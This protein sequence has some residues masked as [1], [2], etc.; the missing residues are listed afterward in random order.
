MA[1]TGGS[2]WITNATFVANQAPAGADIAN[3][4]GMVTMRN[5]T[6]WQAT[7][8]SIFND[9]VT[10]SGTWM[11]NSAVDSLTGP[12]CVGM[13]N[14]QGNVASDDTCSGL[15]D[16][17]PGFGTLD[18]HGG[19]VRTVNLIAGSAAVDAGNF[20]TCQAVDARGISRPQ[21][22]QCDAGAFEVETVYVPV[23][24][25]VNDLGDDADATPGDTLCATATSVCTLRAAIDEANAMTAA[26]SS[27]VPDVTVDFATDGTITVASTLDVAAR[28]AIDGGSHRVTV[29][30]ANAVRVFRF[31]DYQ[32]PY[33]LRHLTI[34][35]GSTAALEGGAGVESISE[36]GTIDR[37][38]FVDNAVT[39]PSSPGQAGGAAVAVTAGHITVSNSTFSGNSVNAT[40]GGA[41]L[42]IRGTASVIH[43]TFGG[44]SGGS[45]FA[46]STYSASI[47][48]DNS[49]VSTTGGFGCTGTITGSAN[50]SADSAPCGGGMTSTDPQFVDFGDHGGVVDTWAIART[51]PAVDAADSASCTPTDARD[52]S[53]PKGAQCDI[54]ALEWVGRT[55]VT[56]ASTA[57]PSVLTQP[58][59]ITANVTSDD[60]TI[61]T[62]TLTFLEGA[63]VLGTAVL[64]VAGVA[65][66]ELPSLSLGSHEITVD[67]PGDGALDPSSA[68]IT[69]QVD[70]PA[71]QVTVT[72]P[73]ST[74]AGSDVSLSVLVDAPGATAAPTGTLTLREGAT[75]I[76]TKAASA[77]LVWFTVS[78]PSTG[79]HN[80]TV[81]YDGDGVYP[82]ASGT[83]DVVVGAAASSVALT[84]AG[85]TVHGQGATFTATVT[86]PAPWLIPTGTVTFTEGAT[87]LGTATLD[88][89]GTAVFV[90]ASLDVGTHGIT[91]TYEGDVNHLGSSASTSHQVDP[92]STSIVVGASD[93]PTVH[94]E[95]VTL[96]A[97][98][99]VDAPG[100]GT[101][102]GT[103]R[104]F[105]GVT[106]LGTATLAAD[107]TT[108][109]ALG[110][111]ST[112][113]H[114]I[115]AT[116]DG[117]SRRNSS[118]GTYDHVVNPAGTSLGLDVT[119]G[120]I[121]AGQAVTLTATV[122]VV[123][124]GAGSP[125]GTVTFTDGVTV[126]GVAAVDGTGVATLSGISFEPGDHE[127]GA[128]YGGDSDF[129]T[130]T[131]SL[132]LTVTKA[133]TSTVVAD[134]VDTTV[135][136]EGVELT[137]TVAVEAPGTGIPTGTVTFTDGATVLGSASLDGTGVATLVVT[138]LEPGSRTVTAT[139]EGDARS[140]VSNGSVEHVVNQAATQVSLVPS[141]ASSVV[142]A[143]VTFTATVTAV[144]PGAGV[145]T[146]SIVFTDGATTLGTVA[147]D[148][149]GTAELTTWSLGVGAHSIGAVF[150]GDAAYLGSSELLAY[151]VDPAGAD[152]V[153]IADAPST[154]SG[155]AVTFTATVT[156]VPVGAIPT[157]VVTFLDGM[158]V[159]GTAGL[160]ATGTAT[161]TTSALSVGMHSVS[162]TYDGD[163]TVGAGSSL[164]L[165]HEVQPASS[166]LVVTSSGSPTVWGESVAITASVS[167]VA[168]G[169]GLP[170]G[171]VVFRE[172]AT[173]LGTVPVDGFGFATLSIPTLS[174]GDHTITADYS[175]DSSFLASSGA[176]LQT[177]E[178]ATATV[179]VT[180]SGSSTVWGE[181]LTI[182]AAVS[183]DAPGSGIA[184]GTVS[185]R[186]GAT[187]LGSATLDAS[188]VAS[189]TIDSLP[190]GSHVLVA[191]YSGDASVD[192]QTASIAHSVDQ[193]T[194]NV[195][196]T[197][198]P[199]P[200]V[201]GQPVTLMA[202]VSV[203]SPGSG[204]ATGTVTFNDG[205]AILGTAT[206]DSSGQAVLA[207][208][209]L[210][211]GT[212]SISA[213]YGG[214]AS[215]LSGSSLDVSHVVDRA[216]SAVAVTTSLPASVWGQPVAVTASVTVVAPGSA[217]PTGTVTFTDGATELGAVAL[218]ATG[219]ATLSTADLDLGART[220]TATYAGDANVM[221]G[222]GTVSHSVTPAGA[223]VGLVSSDPST[224]VGQPV[225]FT[226]TVSVSAPGS[227]T[228]T[229]SVT[230]ES[231]GSPLGSAVV[232]GLGVASLT[233][234][235]LGVGT[236]TVTATYTGDVNVTGASASVAQS[237]AAASTTTVITS[238]SNP[239]VVGQPVTFDVSVTPSG[240][241]VAATGTVEVFDGA[242]LVASAAL[243]ATGS[244][245]VVVADLTV[246]SHS[247]TAHYLGTS[248][249]DASVSSAITQSVD[250]AGSTVSLT[251]DTNP[252]VAGQQVELTAL[253]TSIPAGTLPTGTVTFTDG[254]LT[255]ATAVLDAT[256][257]ATLNT[258]FTAGDHQLI[259]SYS[260]DGTVGP[261][262]STAVVQQVSQ[263]TTSA[264]IVA[265]ASAPVTG[266][267]IELT[268]TI[269]TDAPSVGMPTGTVTFR[270]NATVIGTASLDADGQAILSVDG[271]SA[272]LHTL[273]AD[274]SGDLNRQAS[275]G[276]L[277]LTVAP[278]ATNLA[279]TASSDPSSYGE[280]VTL[281]A[282]V[283]VVAPGTDAVTG[284][285]TGTVT[286]R[287]GANVLA[288]TTL[289]GLGQASHAVAL[290]A[291]VHTIA[292]DYEGDTNF[293]ASTTTRDITVTA[294]ATTLDLAVT[295]P[296]VYGS[297][298]TVTVT[299]STATGVPVTGCVTV[300]FDGKT[301]ICISLNASGVG[302]FGFSGVTPG[303]YAVNASYAGTAD[304][305]PA[306]ATPASATVVAAPTTVAL[307]ASPAAVSAYGQ[308]VS[309]TAT[310]A[311]SPNLSMPTGT[312]AFSSNGVS[313][314]SASVD[315]A[316]KATLP[317]TSLVVG[318]NS[319]V[320]TFTSTNGY[321]TTT[322]PTLS[323]TVTPASTT[324]A[325]SS[326]AN[327]AVRGQVLTLT[328]TVAA[329]SPGGGIPAGTVTFFDG[330]D[331]IGT[332][333]TDAL[334]VAE[335]VT[336]TLAVGAHSLTASFASSTSYSP[337]TS[338]PLAIQ[339]DRSP[340]AVSVTSATTPSVYGQPV[341][342]TALVTATSSGLGVPTGTVTFTDT[343]NGASYGPV[344]LD[345]GGRASAAIAPAVSGTVLVVASYSGDADVA[346]SSGQVNQQVN[347]A[348]TTLTL[349]NSPV[350]PVAG[351]PVSVT[352]TLAAVS[353]GAGTPT[354]NVH[355]SV[356]G[357]SPVSIALDAGGRA[358]INLTGPL[359]EPVAG[360][361]RVTATYDGDP[362]RF[363]P[364]N[365]ETMVRVNRA[366]PT[367]SVV[368]DKAVSPLGSPVTFTASFARPDAVPI[369]AEVIT[370]SNGSTVL[371]S[372]PLTWNGQSL[373]ASL[374]TSALAIGAQTVTASFP[375]NDN[376]VP[377][378]ASTTV[379]VGVVP[380]TLNLVE[381]NGGT[382]GKVTHYIAYVATDGTALPAGQV[383]FSIDGAFVTSSAVVADV[384]PGWGSAAFDYTY[385]AAG[386]HTVTATYVPSGMFSSSTA[387]VTSTVYPQQ[388]TLRISAP[389][390]VQWGEHVPVTVTV[391]SADTPGVGRTGMI[392]IDDGEGQNCSVPAD[393]GGRCSLWYESPGTRTLRATYAGDAVWAPATA[394]TSVDVNYRTPTL[395]G[396]VVTKQVVTGAPT[397]V[398]WSLS[399][400]PD[401]PPVTVE[402]PGGPSCSSQLKTGW[403]DLVLPAETADR[404]VTFTISYP[405]DG[406]YLPARWTSAPIAPLGCYPLDVSVNPAGTAT[407]QVG[408][409]ASC[410]GGR[411]YPDGTLVPVVVTPV[412]GFR[413]PPIDPPGP[414]TRW[415][416]VGNPSKGR[417]TQLSV[418]TE[419][420][421]R[422]V[423]LTLAKEEI[424]GVGGS[425][426]AASFSDK[427]G[428]SGAPN[429]VIGPNGYPVPGTGRWSP[430]PYQPGA[431]EGLFL[432]GT[433][434][435]LDASLDRLGFDGHWFY[436]FR[437][438]GPRSPWS[439]AGAQPGEDWTESVK[440]TSDTSLVAVF[441]PTCQDVTAGVQGPGEVK[442]ATPQNCRDPRRSGWRLGT[443]VTF[444][445]RTQA[446]AYVE[447][448]RVPRDEKNLGLKWLPEVSM[449]EITA[450][451]SVTTSSSGTGTG[452]AISTDTQKLTVE[453]A[454]NHVVA[455]FNTCTELTMSIHGMGSVEASPD[456]NCPTMSGWHF[457][458]GTK[459]DLTAVGKP[460]VDP[461]LPEGFRGTSLDDWGPGIPFELKWGLGAPGISLVMDSDRHI[462][463]TFTTI[464]ACSYLVIDIAPAG[465]GSVST[466]GIGSHDCPN[467]APSGP[468]TEKTA[469]RVDKQSR[470]V[471]LSA[472]P[473]R[474]APMVGWDLPSYS[475]S[476]Y[477][478]TY[479]SE[480][481]RYEQRFVSYEETSRVGIRGTDAVTDVYN[482]GRVTAAFCQRIDMR[483]ALVGVDGK[484]KI[485]DFPGGADSIADDDAIRVYP[486]PNCPYADDAWI[487]G[488]DVEVAALADPAGF[489]FKAWSGASVA[490]TVVTTVHLDGA[491][492]S[493]RLTATYDLRCVTL[494]TNP[495]SEIRRFPEPNCLG[496][497]ASKNRYVGGT[498][499]VLFGRL[500]SDTVFQGWSGDV[501]SKDDKRSNW[502][503]MDRD[504]T[505]NFNYRDKDVWET[506]KS[507]FEWLGD[508]AAI[509]A[510]KAVGVLA[511]GIGS[512]LASA[513]PL[514]FATLIA[515]ISGVIGS[516]LGIF[517]VD[518]DITTYLKYIQETVAF[519]TAGFTCA[520][521]WGMSSSDTSSRDGNLGGQ[522]GEIGADFTV[523]SRLNASQIRDLERDIAQL[524]GKRTYGVNLTD[525]SI[526]ETTGL[527]TKAKLK[528]K[529]AQLTRNATIEPFT[530]KLGAAVDLGTEIYSIS[531]SGSGIG[532]DSSAKSAWTN[533][534]VFKNCALEAVPSMIDI[535]RPQS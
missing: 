428:W 203:A 251:S 234:D 132:D 488:T 464:G 444:E 517:G 257:T 144:A 156:A 175:G 255:I 277:D 58:V 86:G 61:P 448:W 153:V 72:G 238:S 158:T 252:S 94:G 25:T 215:V 39:A 109:L 473:S 313:L 147:L 70:S 495:A 399:G 78:R 289:D 477:T 298:V 84:T 508:Q 209:D 235:L 362:G 352:A 90:D 66:L 221:S 274:Y 345:A 452:G 363:G 36:S 465:A 242:T 146:G 382:P 104:F 262:V 2:L 487:V 248:S 281:A 417:V 197:S 85:S 95:A 62:G 294:V 102:T 523:T 511:A 341:V 441:G 492:R 108:S 231:D 489:T 447:T 3:S 164:P 89:T 498:I 119:T 83:V 224:T 178:P 425:L 14:G 454:Q 485:E 201:V 110:A 377:V 467:T 237:V 354:G 98:V 35:D 344:T 453:R 338:T 470:N 378:A 361:Y 322:S 369:P 402:V 311:R 457:K 490:D 230:F 97:A 451:N 282:Q 332:A 154:V 292:I 415:V 355:F 449:Y 8:G 220:I 52:V 481:N 17:S 232:D 63:T 118:A 34:R 246:G 333:S 303:T 288:T 364:S 75:V 335:L 138:T 468:I 290:P 429:C 29:S 53:R 159:V 534:D 31:S 48:L 194:S 42:F 149:S 327:P 416:T 315:S 44:S 133:S 263:A 11:D 273:Y 325:L 500:P 140:L 494:T 67:Y 316:G 395:I 210:A 486:E 423:T 32:S 6:L 198:S 319:V 4:A 268:A 528:Y 368:A 187:V 459:V 445:A 525:N 359:G 380:T 529:Q 115:T 304:I 504:K 170:T 418:A 405:G 190:V 23:N 64:D 501:G 279:V 65:S 184:T 324:T 533:G 387:T 81:E 397:R 127:L 267:P 105:E 191:D 186:S 93:G 145:P 391:S 167:V 229:G 50:I 286:F 96:T 18:D 218:D 394:A 124:P 57:N 181:S 469:L 433:T 389:Q 334:G 22:A 150:G 103:V 216:A 400:G 60:G 206:L 148:S 265:D 424:A 245:S 446:P 353:P 121:V 137:A 442:I 142:G 185:F 381:F 419:P 46:D 71:T 122:G 432:V 174:V 228:P 207:V 407:V 79:S 343:A 59:T 196:V 476:E 323:H 179:V 512:F 40:I 193:A 478:R 366:T 312:V 74:S 505:A 183:V 139:Y 503:L 19:D 421:Y 264:I 328:A 455:T 396:E 438:Q 531:Q 275:T 390:Q 532:W 409:G 497:S 491:Q 278:A 499:V 143:P 435:E 412:Q 239:S 15:P 530:K 339:V 372:S 356:N 77:A 7:G 365:N 437:P 26:A 212:H 134:S 5:V 236:H 360:S 291:G 111:L 408:A 302:S 16:T 47:T 168:P 336:S 126:L 318:G 443:E 383:Q 367:L 480:P 297:D 30:G 521:A 285:P 385:P 450:S 507:G 393:T 226:A 461:Q 112:G 202:T 357:A 37:V 161:L 370:F 484:Q 82:A 116:Y 141:T 258:V 510:K 128:S 463:P 462:E 205:P 266:E 91:A 223:T 406:R 21:G 177:V 208:S 219:N 329:V 524:Q 45:L 99:T 233:T 33:T 41:D 80:Y 169:T 474:G 314:G 136:G 330:A 434:V 129:A 337:S 280:P 403:C 125:T 55:T 420:V 173:V 527:Y 87:T 200:S 117:D 514:G 475:R 76:D 69:Q 309:F 479:G 163:G 308:S 101:P 482:G 520:A 518:G 171:S 9:D 379:E 466:Q 496:E 51:S 225:T 526:K 13:V 472:T 340:S 296:T 331:P 411:G 439:D 392:V 436:G 493:A 180:T 295:S 374:T 305:A 28:I 483:V 227:G 519:M 250:A 107:G 43:S 261:G 414:V 270:E 410:D 317:T 131:N 113:T 241:P 12:D 388:V 172:G 347:L 243:D 326:S 350:S 100:A 130:S 375:G 269:S 152:V 249:F 259:A 271:L 509:V 513:P 38:T 373:V 192:P 287:E 92:S 20:D 120:P 348:G 254:G 349:A 276:T 256:G 293:A 24:F 283:D 522:L 440:L 376:L 214:D 310:I 10:S 217:T 471:F 106:L 188:G 431:T 358:S 506:I 160:D 413:I 346:P 502:V 1:V 204:T 211:V 342:F 384:Q 49:I 456:G 458:P 307:Q 195:M 176:L 151:T 68:A 422:C 189:L 27:D 123:A 73:P 371:G 244:A 515:G 114:S 247:V 321:A 300:T 253:V 401:A 272:G 404:P 260:G 165:S 162:V 386:T 135:T 535:P 301:P 284:A 306:S 398:W 427:T 516:I 222:S 56:L 157:G 88:G 320:A 213:T 54:G 199:S 240:T 166:A 182:S 299:A 351:D 430:H 460:P 426:R 155:E